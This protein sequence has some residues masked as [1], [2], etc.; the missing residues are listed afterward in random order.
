MALIRRPGFVASPTFVIWNL[1]GILD[2][3]VAVGTGALSQ[4]FTTG[5]VGE[6]TTTP[7]AQMP[8]VLI[9]AFLVPLFVMLHVTGLYQARD[10][11]RGSGLSPTAGERS[12]VA[13]IK[14]RPASHSIGPRELA[15]R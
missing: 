5:A 3:F 13:A 12:T 7:M 6:V 2:L 9:P 14:E 1:L 15:T 4:L 8:L 10:A 11:A